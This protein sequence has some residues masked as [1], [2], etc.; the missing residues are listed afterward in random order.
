LLPPPDVDT[1][2]S[3]TITVLTV[4]LP[5]ARASRDPIWSDKK[6][7]ENDV[8]GDASVATKRDPLLLPKNKFEKKKS[9]PALSPP[10]HHTG[11]SDRGESAGGNNTS[12]T[13]VGR[14]GQLNDTSHWIVP[15][16]DPAGRARLD[17]KLVTVIVRIDALR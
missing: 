3:S 1:D 16:G 13:L 9:S 7:V 5:G 10:F 12:V 8:H 11:S 2:F 4:T 15:E 6:F 14:F 17:E